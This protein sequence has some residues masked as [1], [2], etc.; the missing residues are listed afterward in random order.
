[1]KPLLLS[2]IDIEGGAGRAA[3]RLHCGLKELGL[4]SEML[5]NIK[6]SDDQDVFAP[7][8]SI[9]RGLSHI[10]PGIDR[11]PL[12]LYTKRQTKEFSCQWLPDAT[13]AR[14]KAIQPDVVNVHWVCAGLAS[15]HTLGNINY[16]TVWTLHDMWAFTG[17][18]H[19]TAD[20]TRYEMMCGACPKLNS[21]QEWD[22]S[23]WVWKHK[24]SKWKEIAPY[25]VTP[26]QWLAD[27]V[28]RSSLL[29][30]KR[31]AVIPNGIDLSL[32]R[33]VEKALARTLLN[34]PVDKTLLLFGAVK[35]TQDP[36][37][38]FQL[39]QP[40]L[41]RLKTKSEEP[42]ELAILGAS[43]LDKSIDL[44]F[45][46]RCL[47]ILKDDLTLALAYSAADVF[48]AP[49]LQDNLPNTVLEALAC[50]TPCVAFNIGG[51]PDLIDHQ[52]N[53]FLAQPYEVESLADGIQWVIQADQAQHLS[54]KAR[55]KAERSFSLQLQASRYRALF[56]EVIEQW[57][58]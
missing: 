5:V 17:G 58:P 29:D 22:L 46:T 40:A 41:Q 53:G 37:K 54:D 14:I 36:R 13:L 16:P 32:Y 39:L 28:R 9:S 56:K 45:K 23:R 18:C 8:S 6:R 24:L 31:I 55:E 7:Q 43:S 25:I 34:L 4:S 57:K 19:Y 15:I 35:P 21:T 42:L 3:Y 12:S 49:S 52:V 27:C 10:R 48:I 33:P 1:M 26:S 20:C 38:G 47:G 30:D 44:G 50:G 51:M 2:T 11:L